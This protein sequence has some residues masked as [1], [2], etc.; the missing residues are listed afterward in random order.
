MITSHVYIPKGILKGFSEDKKERGALYYYDFFKERIERSTPLKFNVIEDYYNTSTEKTL[1]WLYENKIIDIR[2][3]IVY[4]GEK[5]KRFSLGYRQKETLYKYLALQKIR[6]GNVIRR[7]GQYH[8]ESLKSLP[9]NND[10]Y[11]KN[12]LEAKLYMY[13]KVQSILPTFIRN[14][15]LTPGVHSEL[16]ARLGI[17]VFWNETDA[18]L[19]LTNSPIEIPNVP[20]WGANILVLSPKIAIVFADKATTMEVFGADY[21][22]GR[23]CR[24]KD[25]RA[26]NKMTYT[27]AKCNYPQILLGDKNEIEKVL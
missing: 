2:E 25:I 19:L 14:E 27:Q 11:E 12:I 17:I 10:Y 9:L 23:I 6:D 1:N 5:G 24:A 3:K 26:F 7:Y 16:A 15:M 13:G 20:G 4:S 22:F 18:N 21:Y 8:K